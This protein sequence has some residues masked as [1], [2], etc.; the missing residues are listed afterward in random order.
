MSLV[1]A[2]AFTVIPRSAGHSD[3]CVR[4]ENDAMDQGPVELGQLTNKSR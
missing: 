3:L 1:P 2:L 4:L